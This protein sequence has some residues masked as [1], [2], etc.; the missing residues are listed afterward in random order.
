MMCAVQNNNLACVTFLLS[1]TGV[2]LSNCIYSMD[3]PLV[4]SV[5]EGHSQ[6]CKL[7]LDFNA[8]LTLSSLR[9][10]LLHSRFQIMTNL[11]EYNASTD[12]F[13]SISSSSARGGKYASAGDMQC[14]R[15]LMLLKRSEENNYYLDRLDSFTP[16]PRVYKDML[17][18]CLQYFMTKV[19][20]QA[21][22]FDNSVAGERVSGLIG[23]KDRLNEMV[24][25]IDSFFVAVDQLLDSIHIFISEN[26]S[27]PNLKAN[28]EFSNLVSFAK[29]VF[30]RYYKPKTLKELCRFKLRKIVFDAVSRY[31]SK[32]KYSMKYRKTEALYDMLYKLNVPTGYYRDYLMHAV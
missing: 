7:L 21:M 24:C 23:L 13:Y 1:Q 10:S 26:D 18:D 29:S 25:T 14:I 28:V 4:L 32:G 17:L 2:D 5:T 3:T 27:Q 9:I 19:V 22:L 16:S 20:G 6:M 12:V 8:P 11:L 31:Q 15:R 30:K